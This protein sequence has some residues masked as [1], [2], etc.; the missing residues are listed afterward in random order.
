MAKCTTLYVEMA[1][2]FVAIILT[3]CTG[4][5]HSSR[6][7][8]Y[9]AVSVDEFQ[10]IL[11]WDCRTV[12]VALTGPWECL[13]ECVDVEGTR[14]YG[15]AYDK[16][17]C[18]ICDEGGQYTTSPSDVATMAHTYWMSDSESNVNHIKWTR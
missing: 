2:R 18:W 1:T 12:T 3:V 7:T 11:A 14:C 13:Q 10:S 6:D 5:T 9:E 15:F 17:T 4:Q 8:L 16:E